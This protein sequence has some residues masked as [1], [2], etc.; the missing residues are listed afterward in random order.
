MKKLFS[1]LLFSSL[2]FSS[3]LFSSLLFSSLLF[4]SLL[5]SSLLFPGLALANSSGKYRPVLTV[6]D[7]DIKIYQPKHY[8]YH[9]TYSITLKDKDFYMNYPKSDADRQK[10]DQVAANLN[11]EVEKCRD[12]YSLGSQNL[13]RC[14]RRALGPSFCVANQHFVLHVNVLT[15]K[16]KIRKY[17]EYPEHAPVILVDIISRSKHPR[18]TRTTTDF[19]GGHNS[20]L[21]LDVSIRENRYPLDCEW[22][23]LRLPTK[24]DYIAPLTQSI[25][26]FAKAVKAGT[27]TIPG[28]F[29]LGAEISS[30]RDS[31][32]NSL[33]S[34]ERARAV[35]VRD[36]N[37][38][39]SNDLAARTKD[40]ITPSGHNECI[41]KMS[42]M[43]RRFVVEDFLNKG[44]AG[45]T[46]YHSRAFF[47]KEE[48]APIY[49]RVKREHSQACRANPW[50]NPHDYSIAPFR[51]L[52]PDRP[53]NEV[54]TY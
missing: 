27:V 17:R 40:Y 25:N 18:M 20:H 22:Y 53:G 26:A 6:K 37:A 11:V 9:D 46:D 5:F 36:Y 7:K 2:L 14:A 1:S 31:L 28:D 19:V 13:K 42:D 4:S 41:S 50:K 23:R 38:K 39:C 10:C 15:P 32:K 35:Y 12:K 52:P 33:S 51:D 44:G 8:G 30:W 43:R 3:L 24:D 34:I 48:I 21:P 49:L 54:L 45:F 47:K 16:G 29:G